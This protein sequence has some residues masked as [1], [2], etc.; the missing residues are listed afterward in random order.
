MLRAP[1]ICWQL[2]LLFLSW[3]M[4]AAPG[5]LHFSIPGGVYTD[6]ISLKL[7]AVSPSAAIHFTIDGSEPTATSAVYSAALRI[8]NPT[9]VR[10]RAF[11][12]EK[13]SGPGVTETYVFL[14]AYA[15]DF[16]SDL[17]LVIINTFGQRLSHEGRVPVS[18]RFIDVPKG[19]RAALTTPADFD[20]RAIM[21]IRGTSSLQ[22]PKH[23]F[24]FRTKEDTGSGRKFPILGFPPDSE[25]V[26]YAPYPD[27]RLM[28]DVLAYEL[29]RQ[30]GHYAPRTRFDEAFLSN[31]GRRLSR[32]DYAGV[33]V[34]EEKIKASRDRVNIA[35][36]TP[37][38]NQEPEIS[39]GYIFKKDHQDF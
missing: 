31:S 39:G 4:A 17:P 6:E 5:P 11:E 24:T 33:Y 14:E 12:V 2:G 37:A 9:I 15:L 7:S 25:W 18:I 3:S 35:S 34:F 23:S 20:G 26:L 29:S 21:N 13:P 8:T 32:R 36:L 1:G 22:F 28:R 30:M 16:A 19:K 10:A 27:K 38:D